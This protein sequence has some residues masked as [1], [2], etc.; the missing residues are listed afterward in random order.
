M[1]TTDYTSVI[2][3]EAEEFADVA[4]AADLSAGVPTCPGWDFAKLLTHTGSAHRWARGVVETREPLAP[5][6]ID[7]QLP[8]D[9]AGLPDW[10]EQG[11][12]ALVA[13]LAD[14]DPEASCWTWAGDQH[15]RF[16][17]RR[18]AFE[19]AVHRWDGQLT[20]GAPGTFDADFAVDGIHE[21][22]LNRPF[23]GAIPP[24]TGQTL[25]LH[26][27]D[28]AGEWLLTLGPDG[29]DVRPEHAK[30]DVALRGPAADLLLVLV[31][32][33]PPTSVE[34][35]GDPDDLGPWAEVL[36]F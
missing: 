2:T 4:R 3:A 20:A 13:T 10:L 12:A 17:P 1:T 16:W 22:L 5:K 18:M 35:H 28:A 34:V 11:A 26:A 9:P 6:S 7:R 14:A 25:H 32:R 30:G 31:G 15:V 29:L 27:T 19:T 23:L 8:D 24:G 21:H 36:H 33:R